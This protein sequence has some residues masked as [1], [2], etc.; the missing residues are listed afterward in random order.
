[1]NVQ[2]VP[3]DCLENY[4]AHEKTLT[5]L[6][7]LC[8]IL[9]TSSNESIIISI[10]KRDECDGRQAVIYENHGTDD[11][12]RQRLLCLFLYLWAGLFHHASGV[13]LPPFFRFFLQADALFTNFS[14]CLFRSCNVRPRMAPRPH[15]VKFAIFIV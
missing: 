11:L 8:Q 2:H 4:H 10:Y 5:H 9:I 3:K 7:V 15:H 13:T 14:F 12:D 1:M 6:I